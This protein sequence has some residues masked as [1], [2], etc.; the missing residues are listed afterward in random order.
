MKTALEK[1]ELSS[2]WVLYYCKLKALFD[3]DEDVDINFNSG[4]PE[5]SMNVKDREKAY[6]IRTLIPSEIIFGNVILKINV[7][8]IG[9]DIKNGS[10][11]KQAF[12]GN[13]IISYIKSVDGILDDPLEYI[14]FKPDVVQY[15]ADNLSD[16][17]GNI[18]S[19]YEN[20]AKDVFGDITDV[21]FCTD[22][23]K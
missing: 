14:V 13:P 1:L 5:I 6:A 15:F 12:K 19:I 8:Y 16:I 9:P 20:I 10:L 22:I 17:N 18:T 4:I 11:F 3:K 2:E 23:V 21:K 7:A